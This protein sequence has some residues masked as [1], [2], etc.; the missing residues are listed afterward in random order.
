M[1]LS[2][3]LW[4]MRTVGSVMHES[5]KPPYRSVERQ[6]QQRRLH[7]CRGSCAAEVLVSPSTTFQP[8]RTTPSGKKEFMPTLNSLMKPAFE[9]AA[10]TSR[11]LQ[12]FEKS[13]RRLQRRGS[14]VP[15]RRCL[16]SSLCSEDDT[17]EVSRVSRP[18]TPVEEDSLLPPVPQPPRAVVELP[19]RLFSSLLLQHNSIVSRLLKLGREEVLQRLESEGRLLGMRE[20]TSRDLFFLLSCIFEERTL[21]KDD[22]EYLFRFF[23]W[24]GQGSLDFKALLD[25]ASLLFAPSEVLAAVHF[26]RMLRECVLDDSVVAVADVEVMLRALVHI[27][28]TEVPE[29]AALCGEVRLA[30]ED[31]TP[32]YTVPVATLRAEVCRFPTLRCCLDAVEWDGSIDWSQLPITRP[33]DN[34]GLS[35]VEQQRE[36]VR[37]AIAEGRGPTSPPPSDHENDCCMDVCHPRFV[38]DK[39]RVRTSTV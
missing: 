34:L 1:S 11:D 39:H 17:G 38:A 22:V 25:S 12:S 26:R 14:K 15:S 16:D 9:E 35:H 28:G 29:V 23:D 21:W 7:N 8:L 31:L 10:D 30:V 4:P 37:S 24:R 19:P 27:F 32:A 6:P 3:S 33:A 20:V 2:A 5:P 18:E 13:L 36:L